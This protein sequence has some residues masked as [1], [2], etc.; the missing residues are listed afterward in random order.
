MVNPLQNRSNDVQENVEAWKTVLSP[1][2]DHGENAG[3]AVYVGLERREGS[4]KTTILSLVL[5]AGLT[6]LQ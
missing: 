1:V 4:M 6:D 5:T 2:P 3:A